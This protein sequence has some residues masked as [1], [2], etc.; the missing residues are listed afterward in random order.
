ML[1]TSL[2]GALCALSLLL[3]GC[4]NDPGTG[5]L[6]VVLGDAPF[7]YEMVSS[8]EI[9]VDRVQVRVSAENEDESGWV[10]LQ[11][12]DGIYD[13]LDLQN[14]ITAPLANA[15]LPVGYVD[16]IRL[17]ISSGKV[18]LSDGRLFALT[19]PSG[20]SSGLKVF[21]RPRIAVI[22]DTTTEVLLDVDVSESFQSI[23]SSPTQV[24]EISGFHFDPVLRVANLNATGSVSGHVFSA[25]STALDETDDV[26]L[27]NAQ[28]MAYTSGDTTSTASDAEGFYR[29]LGLAPGSWTL[30]TSAPGFITAQQTVQVVA[31]IDAGGNDAHLIPIP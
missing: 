5:H 16:Q 27:A 4:G 28:V 3:A 29:I 14:G 6:R 19:V 11:G 25:G 10:A 17:V 22:K 26:P 2:F 12:G 1:R 31:G 21:V 7:P 13:L 18:K 23:P 9:T 24:A 30:E 15:E 20:S 8:A